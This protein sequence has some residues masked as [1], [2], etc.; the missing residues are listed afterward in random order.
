MID[1]ARFA[2]AERDRRTGLAVIG[3]GRSV[4]GEPLAARGRDLHGHHAGP[5]ILE[6]RLSRSSLAP[7]GGLLRFAETVFGND[8]LE[9]P[10]VSEG[11]EGRRIGRE[12]AHRGQEVLE[13][14]M[15]GIA[16]IGLDERLHARQRP[17]AAHLVQEHPEDPAPL[18]VGHG[19]IAGPFAGDLDQRPLRVGLPVPAVAR[20]EPLAEVDP[21]VEP[22]DLFDQ[23]DRGEVGRPFREDVAARALC[24]ASGYC[25]TTG[26]RPRGAVISKAAWISGLLCVKKPIP[27]ENVMFVGNPWA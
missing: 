23:Q 26:G 12:R 13:H 19:R 27:S 6:L 5:G 3:A 15:V 14:G 7:C 22:L 9:E 8:H 25:P 11:V 17:V 21:G 18:V 10:L 2:L 16:V 1:V 20:L 4:L 24:P